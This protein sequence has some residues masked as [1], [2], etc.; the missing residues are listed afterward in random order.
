MNRSGR[1]KEDIASLEG[2]RRFDHVCSE[3]HARQK[4]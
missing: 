4:W 1:H 3:T 2:R